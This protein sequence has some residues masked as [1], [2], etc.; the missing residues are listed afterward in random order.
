MSV[1]ELAGCDAFRHGLHYIDT[2]FYWEAHEVLEP[3]WMAL[4][5]TSE[6]RRLVQALIQI[7]NAGLKLEMGRPRAAA[8]L[9]AIAH[10]L[11]TSLQSPGPLGV[12]PVALN[13]LVR[14][15]EG[16]AIDAK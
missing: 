15:L 7:A 12:D 13:L 10:Q 6:E 9:C 16:Q 1:R 11:L 4:P 2:G 5:E 14:Y 3:V 8:R